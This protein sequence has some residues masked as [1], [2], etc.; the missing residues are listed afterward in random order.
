MG[1]VKI[2]GSYADANYSTAS[3]AAHAHNWRVQSF[4]EF[5]SK[6]CIFVQIASLNTNIGSNWNCCVQ[7]V[8]TD[9]KGIYLR[10]WLVQE[11]PSKT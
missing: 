3:F 9:K 8:R 1:Y 2:F 7:N 10:D 11:M 6:E 5:A 4:I